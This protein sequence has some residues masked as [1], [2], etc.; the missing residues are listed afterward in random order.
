LVQETEITPLQQKLETVATSISKFGLISAVLVLLVLIIRFLVDRGV[1][2]TW[3]DGQKYT[4]LIRFVIIAISV[5]A[6][7][8]PEGLP[9]AVTLTLAFSVKKMMRDNNLVRRLHATETMGGADNICSDKTGTLTQNKMNLTNFWNEKLYE[10]DPYIKGTLGDSFPQKYHEILKQALACNGS[11]TLEPLFG[12]K[13]EVALLEFLQNRGEDYNT[14]RDQYLNATSIKFPFSS[15]RKRMSSVLENVEN[16][17]PSKKRMHIKGASEIVLESCTQFHS[18]EE[19]R[20]IPMTGTMKQQI[21][22]EI[23]NMAKKALR[24][25]CIAYKEVSGDEGL[26]FLLFSFNNSNFRFH[27]QR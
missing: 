3:D 4:Q 12:S 14:I 27:H 18:F 23:E 15:Q 19:D 7:A 9:L 1:T 10:V 16:G 2:H 20:V 17:L 21:E 24:T 13:T 22:N 26:L 25:I 8:I 11:A 6:V 5:L